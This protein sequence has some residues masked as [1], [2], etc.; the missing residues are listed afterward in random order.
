[1]QILQRIVDCKENIFFLGNRPH[2]ELNKLYNIADVLVLPSRKEALPLVAIESLA[3][4]TP[5]VVT[6]KT[7]MEDIITKDVG[8][9]F[10]MDNDQMLADRINSVLNKEVVFNSQELVNYAK[11]NYSQ[12]NLMRTILK[13]YEEIRII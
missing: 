6:D 8:L 3:C 10:E 2:N 13:L 5:A 12:E 1:M 11:N 4:G 7:G 9:T